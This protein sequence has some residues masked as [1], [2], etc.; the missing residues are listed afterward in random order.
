MQTTP[1]RF[2]V[3]LVITAL[4]PAAV[5]PARGEGPSPDLERLEDQIRARDD[6]IED[7]EAKMEVL[8]DELSRM[9]EAAAVPEVEGLEPLYGFG[10]AASKVFHIDRGLSIGGYGEVTYT[11]FVGDSGAGS[12]TSNGVSVSRDA[13]DRADA[14]R[15][16]LYFGYKFTDRIVFNSE[17]EFEH[18]F[19]GEETVTSGSGE[20]AVEFMTLDFLLTDWANLR[21]G[22]LLPPM[23]FINEIHEPPFFLGVQ[24]PET[25]RRILPT[26]WRE[27]GV[28]LWG[29]LGETLHYRTY[30]VNGFNARGFS[31]SGIRGGRQNGDRALAEDFAWVTRVDWFPLDGLELGGSVYWGDTGQD[32]ELSGRDLAD[33]DLLILEGH[34][35]YRRGPL[36]LRGLFAV[37]NLADAGELSLALMRPANRPVADKTLGGYLEVGYDVWRLLFA[38]DM[39]LMPFVRVEYVDTQFKV[40]RGFTSNDLRS[41][42]LTTAGVNFKP[43][44]GVVLKLEYRNFDPR[45]GELPDELGIGMG[46]AF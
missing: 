6:R 43:H 4:A 29:S 23:G 24:R 3:F 45:R 21:M 31:D 1:C 32:Q 42:W 44:P 2:L 5:R 19:V 13:L 27:V 39:S 26:T 12:T 7:L 10:P 34:A 17:L 46:F 35:Q 33:A 16:V 30:L 18:A 25:E 41:T 11:N 9:R 14:L 8:V 15:L 40:P 20:V 28:G 38:S 36:H 37:T 22:L